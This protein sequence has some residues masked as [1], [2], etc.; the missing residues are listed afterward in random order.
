MKISN[1]FQFIKEDV[2]QDL[3]SKLSDEN[4]D[5]K[6]DI[7]EMITKSVNSE[8]PKM[9][10]EFIDSIIRNTEDSKIEGLISDADIYEFYEKYTNQV[11]EILSKIKFYDTKP[12]EINSFSLYK[13]VVKGTQKAILDLVSDIKGEISG[14]GGEKKP[15]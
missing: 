1:Y 11:D 3:I 2:S 14:Q 6:T 9:I 5:I 13:F 8:D 12:S 15:E 10:T 4:K 7:L